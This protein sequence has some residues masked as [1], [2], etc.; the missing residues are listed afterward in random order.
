DYAATDSYG[1]AILAGLVNTVVVSLLAIV[2]ATVCGTAVGI[3]QLSRNPLLALLARIYVEALRNIPLLLYLF[4]WYALIVMSLPPAREAW[5]VLPHVFLTNGG[6]ALPSLKMT[7]AD[8]GV[9]LAV[10]LGCAL[11][12]VVHRGMRARRIATGRQCTVWPWVVLAMSAPP[13]IVAV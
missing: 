2:L 7:S 6:L 8:A 13:M 1:R 10:F 4:F 9:F 5:E 12:V 11:A 3:A